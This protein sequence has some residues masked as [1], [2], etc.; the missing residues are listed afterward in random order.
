MAMRRDA[1]QKRRAPI[2]IATVRAAALAGEGYSD[3]TRFTSATNN[4]GERT[5]TMR[6]Y[7]AKSA[8]RS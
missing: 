1:E 8:L 2:R 6:T 7:G 5:M 4:R 3:G